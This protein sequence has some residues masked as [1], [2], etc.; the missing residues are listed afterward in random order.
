MYISAP[1]FTVNVSFL[2]IFQQLSVLAILFKIL[3]TIFASAYFHWTLWQNCVFRVSDAWRQYCCGGS[4]KWP[5]KSCLVKRK[6]FVTF[7]LYWGSFVIKGHKS[8]KWGPV[9][10]QGGIEHL[11]YFQAYIGSF[12]FSNILRICQRI[13]FL[14]WLRKSVWPGWSMIVLLDRLFHLHLNIMQSNETQR[15]AIACGF[16]PML[17][18]LW[19]RMHLNSCYFKNAPQ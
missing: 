1:L 7:W 14:R 11:D 6:Q 8:W 9:K 13:H 10:P 4:P 17:M 18:Q 2:E 15:N 12:L 3:Q 5:V 19:N 16:P